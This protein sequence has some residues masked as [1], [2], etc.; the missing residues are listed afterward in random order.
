MNLTVSP[1]AERWKRWRVDWKMESIGESFGLDGVSEWQPEV[2]V[3][4]SWA[5]PQLSVPDE[6]GIVKHE[7]ELQWLW[8]QESILLHLSC[9]HPAFLLHCMT[10]QPDECV[11]T[12]AG[13]KHHL[14]TFS[15]LWVLVV[16]LTGSCWQ[17]LRHTVSC[18][19]SVCLLC[20]SIGISTDSFGSS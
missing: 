13:S 20:S 2:F 5:R 9:T 8:L 14:D 1:V 6:F 12:P 4:Y 7:H 16:V 3:L 11:V 19:V 18:Q 17:A 15:S 10:V